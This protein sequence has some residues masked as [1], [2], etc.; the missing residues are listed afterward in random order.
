MA[1]RMTDPGLNQLYGV[2]LG[3]S[4]VAAGV[5]G[6]L[7][8]LA[9]VLALHG[10]PVLPARL[11][12]WGGIALLG[13]VAGVMALLDPGSPFTW[14]LVLGLAGWIVLWLI[15]SGRIPDLGILVIGAGVPWAATYLS[16]LVVR[17]TNPALGSVDPRLPLAAVGL[18]AMGIGIMLVIVGP[19]RPRPPS[20]ATPEDRLRIVRDAIERGQA[21]GP[22][23]AP[24][25]VGFGL[26]LAASTV[27]AFVARGLDPV[28]RQA[29]AF[30]AFVVVGIVGWLLAT[31]RRVR[32]AYEVLQWLI[33][34]STADWERVVGYRPRTLAGL[35]RM[36]ERLPDDDELRQL[37][38]ELLIAFGRFDEARLALARLPNDTEWDRFRAADLRQYLAWSEGTPDTGELSVMA[39]AAARIEDH[40]RALRARASVALAR[41]RAD[42]AAGDPDALD[43]LA[44]LRAEVGPRARRYQL[45]YAAGVLIAFV[46]IMVIG[47]VAS[48][49]TVTIFR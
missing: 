2:V 36:L 23:A 4:V 11:V 25:V 39:E 30:V 38:T 8:L 6:L 44:A 29:V 16:A 42:A 37:R 26:G 48:L 5:L 27:V 7:L 17:P 28:P 20:I 32:D 45:P 22:V 15:R 24:W 19:R 9:H 18:V 21:M 1:G 40:E 41:V 47:L 14:L 3:W 46:L 31:P 10:R 34:V 49:A 13:Y 43:H 35:R 33:G 12:R